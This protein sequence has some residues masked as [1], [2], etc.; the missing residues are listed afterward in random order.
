M[1]IQN[2]IDALK[3]NWWKDSMLLEENENKDDF[4]IIIGDLIKDIQS[5]DMYYP[6]NFHN[7][8]LFNFAMFK[9]ES[10]PTEDDWYKVA[11]LKGDGSCGNLIELH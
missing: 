6:E 9:K 2:A 1:T 7:S 10:Q 4:D 5:G 8:Y 3:N 11:V